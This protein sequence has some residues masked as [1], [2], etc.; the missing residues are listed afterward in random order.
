MKWNG[1]GNGIEI[2]MKGNLDRISFEIDI[3][4]K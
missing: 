1:N 4:R 2:E 3:E